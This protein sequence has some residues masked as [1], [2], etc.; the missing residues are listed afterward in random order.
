M[1]QKLPFETFLESFITESTVD[2]TTM[3]QRIVSFNEKFTQNMPELRNSYYCTHCQCDHD[4]GVEYRSHYLKYPFYPKISALPAVTIDEIYHIK[5]VGIY[6][7]HNGIYLRSLLPKTELILQREPENKH[8]PYAVSVW[9]NSKKLGY[10][11]RESNQSIFQALDQE[12]VK[13]IFG[14]YYPGNRT[15]KPRHSRRSQ[16]WDD[17]EDYDDWI[18]HSDDIFSPE[19]ADITIHIFNPS[20]L[21]YVVDLFLCL[22]QM[23]PH[24]QGLHRLIIDNLY[25]AG[26]RV[27]KYLD[28]KAANE[29]FYAKNRELIDELHYKYNIPIKGSEYSILL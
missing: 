12:S 19:R 5:V 29:E 13:C 28:M 26:Y 18:P 17:D 23:Y 16:H 25:E 24:H 9:H 11:P 2:Y 21:T 3:Q 15:Y 4:T 6:Y 22:W 7:T 8:D 27:L 20:K 10:L 1:N 14:T